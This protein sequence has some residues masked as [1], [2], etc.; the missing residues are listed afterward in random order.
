MGRQSGDGA[1]GNLTPT[2]DRAPGPETETATYQR[3][4]CG[5]DPRTGAW[6]LHEKNASPLFALTWSLKPLASCRGSGVESYARGVVLVLAGGGGGRARGVS[7]AAAIKKRRLCR[8]TG[9]AVFR[10]SRRLTIDA[11]MMRG[12]AS[13]FKPRGVL[14]PLPYLVGAESVVDDGAD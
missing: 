6:W 4:I 14:L 3:Q 2:A 13:V 8:G 9:G 12:V 5:S 11:A 1:R 7:G 10:L